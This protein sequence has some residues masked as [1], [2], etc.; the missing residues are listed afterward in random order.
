MPK[1]GGGLPGI[2]CRYQQASDPSS[3]KRAALSDGRYGLCGVGCACRDGLADPRLA[4][5]PSPWIL[6]AAKGSV[7]GPAGCLNW[8]LV[9][10][11]GPIL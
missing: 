6:G 9:S 8:N 10:G 11:W 3:R 7:P 4:Q 1:Q 2:C 5:D